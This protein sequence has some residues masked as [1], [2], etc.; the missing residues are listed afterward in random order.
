M[1]DLKPLWHESVLYKIERPR[2]HPIQIV[3]SCSYNDFLLWMFGIDCLTVILHFYCI[4]FPAM[5]VNDDW[6]CQKL[7][8]Q[9]K[10]ISS[11]CLI[12]VIHRSVY[13]WKKMTLSLSIEIWQ[14]ARQTA[15]AH[16]D[17]KFDNEAKQTSRYDTEN[18]ELGINYVH[19]CWGLY[20]FIRDYSSP[21]VNP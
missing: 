4:C 8:L 11:S 7:Y 18:P 6:C 5:K 21:Q 3:S 20:S 16:W 17:L 15:S 12:S 2:Q 14:T 10:A 9:N 13:S 1:Q 19:Y